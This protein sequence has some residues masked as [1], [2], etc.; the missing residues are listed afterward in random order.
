GLYCDTQFQEKIFPVCT[1]M[2]AGV[3]AFFYA[4]MAIGD[5]IIHHEKNPF[6][7]IADRMDAREKAITNNI[8]NF[9][10]SK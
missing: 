10:E 4:Y 9:L 6:S 8:N 1:L 2:G 5:M 3:G 7:H